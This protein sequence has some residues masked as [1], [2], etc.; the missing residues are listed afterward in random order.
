MLLSNLE[1]VFKDIFKNNASMYVLMFRY[2][3][4]R[5]RMQIIATSQIQHNINIV[6]KINFLLLVTFFFEFFTLL[7]FKVFFML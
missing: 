5:Q 6:H 2:F 3:V 7:Y 4:L 1:M